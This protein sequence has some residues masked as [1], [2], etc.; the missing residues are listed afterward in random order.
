MTFIF[1]WQTKPDIRIYPILFFRI[2]T[3]SSLEIHLS[4]NLLVPA[5]ILSKVQ[6]SSLEL[7]CLTDDPT[8]L[9]ITVNILRTM[10][11]QAEKLI[12]SVLTLL[13]IAMMT[14]SLHRLQILQNLQNKGT[15]R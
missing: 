15:A 8:V 6:I 5:R 10:L 14:P 9:K 11:F 7:T 3:T 4:L 2:R 1:A 12:H 13:Q